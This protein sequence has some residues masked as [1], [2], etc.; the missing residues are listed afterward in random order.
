MKSD[1]LG[2]SPQSTSPRERLLKELALHNDR[3]R[4]QFILKM[5]PNSFQ[6]Y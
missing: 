5:K 2:K 6:E 4:L 3:I 1:H